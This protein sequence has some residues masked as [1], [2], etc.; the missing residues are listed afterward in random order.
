[1]SA[2]GARALAMCLALALAACS[3]Q[4]APPGTRG[5]GTISVGQSLAS[6]Q[7]LD[8]T[9]DDYP[10][11]LDPQLTTD[12][13]SQRVL[14]DLFEGLVTLGIDG[15]PVPGA[16]ASWQHSSDSRTWVFHLRDNARWSNGAAVTAGDFVYSWRRE[17]DPKTGSGYAQ[18]LAPIVNGLDI[19]SGHKPP[20]TLGVE[21]TDAHTLT[22]HLTTPTPYLLD[23]LDQVYLY[24]VYQPAIERYGDDWVRPEHLVC[25][26]AFTLAEDVIGNRLTLQA[27]A[28]YWDA[29]HVA[30]RRV[31]YYSMPDRAQAVLRYLAG[32]VQFT[33]S[34][35]ASQR[36]WLKRTLGEQVVNSPWL[37]IY[38]LAFN[39][40][41]PPFRDNLPLRQALVMAVDRRALTRYLKYDMYE[42]ADTL[43]PPLPGYRPQHP[44]WA[45]LSLDARNALAKKLYAQAGYSAT[46]PLR[47]DISTSIQGA[48]E[49]HF[50]EAVAAMWHSVLG[51]QI[52]VDESEFKVLLQ[53][54]ELH[55]L[56][57]FLDSWIG[58][59]ADPVN[60]LQ[61]FD[62]RSSLDYGGY[63]GV[64]FDAL[65][66]QAALEP[67]N[68]LRYGLLEQAEQA[69][70]AD[71][72][73]LPLYYYA[74]RHLVKPY[75]RGW[76]SNLLDRNLSRY[77]FI[78]EH[79]GN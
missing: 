71:A 75:V 78:L 10:R 33:D 7:S 65:L 15:R 72:V 8:R 1:M 42:P 28:H 54:R 59:F 76:Q 16:A 56:P 47:V 13:P 43:M 57:L 63:Q 4:A 53:N 20:E 17:V 11:S 64:R 58:D 70:D 36:P 55:R 37:G 73:Y 79:Q 9:L 21:A 62:S 50:L 66:D 60:F 2:A 67:D 45:G 51:A 27:N 41:E 34:F 49:R 77:M 74:T 44:Q 25:N 68:T 32:E 24:P 29:A 38:M 40:R 46:H 23:L 35:A 69:L 48:D 12:I 26:G 18:A 5:A 30:L 3:R 52:G 31:T 6:T 39:V 61:L 19:A 14:D 22:V